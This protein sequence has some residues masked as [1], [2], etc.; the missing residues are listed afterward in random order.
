MNAVVQKEIPID[1]LLGEV[2]TLK[3][4]GARFV[5]ITCL[6]GGETLELIYHFD[7][8]Y[9]LTNIRVR[10]QKGQTLPSISPLYFAALLIENEIQD[11]FGI[12]VDGLVIDYHGR[13]L[14]AE[15]A[16]KAPLIKAHGVSI[17]AR[18]KS[19][20]EVKHAS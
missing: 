16:P 14:L 8:D 7:K 19:E 18:V 12:T 17:D 6:D 1:Q 13:F 4:H 11:M 20:T 3:S 5:T 10:I 2:S 9:D 15:D